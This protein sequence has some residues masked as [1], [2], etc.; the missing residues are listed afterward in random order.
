MPF[1]DLTNRD[2][3]R[4]TM[5]SSSSHLD[6]IEELAD[7]FANRQRRGEKP[8]MQEYIARHPNLASEIRDVFPALVMMEHV[9]PETGDLRETETS[10]EP[11]PQLRQ[12]G[13]YRILARA[14][15]WWNGSR[16]RSRAG[17]TSTPRRRRFCRVN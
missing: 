6:L 10:A 3:E 9:A 5:K 8:S 14:G 17:I 16:L 2:I 7:D 15:T 11:V 4:D 1:Q 12:V 13:E